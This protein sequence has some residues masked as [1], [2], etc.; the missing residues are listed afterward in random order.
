MWHMNEIHMLYTQ[1]NLIQYEI[2]M[3]FETYITV[4][5]MYYI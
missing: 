2:S 1:Q 3:I 5:G 4:V